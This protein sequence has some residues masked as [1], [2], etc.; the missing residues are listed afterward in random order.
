M[1]KMK[2]HGGGL[3]VVRYRAA[4]SGQTSGRLLFNQ[5]ADL[6]VNDSGDQLYVDLCGFECGWP[7]TG[8]AN[9]LPGDVATATAGLFKGIILDVTRNGKRIYP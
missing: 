7:T 2:V 8:P 3:Q 9:V 1:G 4:R 6:E 5:S